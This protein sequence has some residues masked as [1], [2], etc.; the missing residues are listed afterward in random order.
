MTQMWNLYRQIKIFIRKF[1]R[2]WWRSRSL[3]GQ[4]FPDRKVMFS[5]T[6]VC[7]QGVSP[8]DRDPLRTKTP[9]SPD[10]DTFWTETPPPLDRDLPPDRDPSGYWNQ[11]AATIGT[12][13][14][15]IHSCSFSCGHAKNRFVPL[16]IQVRCNHRLRNLRS[17]TCIIM[18]SDVFLPTTLYRKHI[19]EG[20]PFFA[21]RI[22]SL[23]WILIV[24]DRI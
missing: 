16:G 21:L 8:L 4:I 20:C 23:L 19:N 11:I 2:V 15:W 12:H 3:R 6:S 7:P 22:R 13:P 1:T 24:Y 10:Q 9:P 18:F 14:T 5:Q 17:T